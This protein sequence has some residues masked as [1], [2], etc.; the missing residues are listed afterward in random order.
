[1]S[2]CS[3]SGSS[4]SRSARSR[5]TSSR[6]RS[7]AHWGQTSGR[8]RG[9][10][11]R[12]GCIGR[13][14]C[15]RGWNRSRSSGLASGGSHGGCRRGCGRSTGLPRHWAGRSARSRSRSNRC[16]A[17]S[18]IAGVNRF[19][20]LHGCWLRQTARLPAQKVHRALLPCKNH[21]RHNAHHK[22]C[23]QQGLKVTA[24]GKNHF[25][26]INILRSRGFGRSF[27][28]TK[29]FADFFCRKPNI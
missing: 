12:G 14:L 5:S 4:R 11:R 27:Q 13:R 25:W 7:S 16:R 10:T 22:Y 15:G 17:A 6:G 1:M 23:G 20:T 2:W 18:Q 24:R 28:R 21:H 3:L 29:R 9:L 19:R 8:L 26:F